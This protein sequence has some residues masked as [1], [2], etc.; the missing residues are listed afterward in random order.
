M[1]LWPVQMAW[2]DSRR[3]RRRLLLYSGAIVLGIAALVAVG[4]FGRTVR[5]ALDAQANALLGAD[6]V[7]SARQPFTPTIDSFVATLGGDQAREITFTSMTQFPPTGATRLTQVRAVAGG[8]P[9]YGTLETDPPAA[10]ALYRAGQGVLLEES[11][12]TQFNATVGDPVRLGELTLPI[13]GTLRRVPGE[14]FAFATFAPRV[15]VPFDAVG[16]SQLLQPGSLARYKVY[17]RWRAGT[18]VAGLVTRLQPQLARFG[19]S[20]ETVAKRK[21]N[22]GTTLENADRFLSLVGFVALLLGGIGIASAIHV[23]VHQRLA[24][25]AILRCLGSS[26]RQTFAVY[27][28]QGLALGVIGA[29]LGTALGLSVHQLLPA[30]TRD[31]LPFPVV[32]T[33]AW[34]ATAQ[35]AVVGFAICG[36]FAL[37]PLLAVRRVP[38]LAALRTLGTTA[39]TAWTDPLVWAIYALL[40]AGIVTMA[41]AQSD[42]W[43]Q[44]LGFA[45]GLGGVVGLLAL[46]AKLIAA[47]AR[48]LVPARGPYVLRQGVANL[49]RPHNRTVLLTLAL[50]LGTFL[51]LTLYLVHATL[52]RHLTLQRQDTQP[53]ALLFD[54]QPDQRAAVA[55]L[56]RSLGFTVFQEAPLVSMRLARVRGRPVAEILADPRRTAPAWALRREYR[57]TYRDHFTPTETP[58][59]GQ[60][61]PAPWPAGAPVPISIEEGIAKDLGVG[62]HDEIEFDVQGI[63]L[64]TRVTSVRQV[65][66]RR[67]QPNFFVVFPPGVLED[68]PAFHVLATRVTDAAQS[69]TLQ[70]AVVERFANVSAI[71]LTLIIQTVDTVVAKIAAVIRFMAWFT[72]GTGLV[73]LVAVLATGRHQRWRETLLLQTLGA[74]RRQVGGIL[75]VEYLC[76]GGLAGLTG[77]LLAVAADW[78]LARFVFKVGFVP[79]IGPVGLALGITAGLTLLTGLLASRGS[80]NQSPLELLRAAD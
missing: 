28:I 68:A 5:D 69:A 77:C 7:L 44:G 6:L 43:T 25:V 47:A 18:D 32:V 15:F 63:P 27:L 56:V 36:L 46:L 48:R 64:R 21:E 62:L 55:D 17:L 4:S 12:L 33:V 50:G 72:V 16:R 54:I 10:A 49:Y 39:G 19:L 20:A 71:D 37:L 74:S 34:P 80:R 65:D 40:A 76:L 1:N 11:L 14:S 53:N 45:A 23:H 24:T 70:R 8:F 22:L 60:W 31:L 51:I 52:L 9:F 38:P 67:V 66:W 2:R 58:R 73:V 75:T 13:V 61:P 3:S 29:G 78:A 35:A 42:R 30:L 57:S 79:A 26:V 59:A 41:V